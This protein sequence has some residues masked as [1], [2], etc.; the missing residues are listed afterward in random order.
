MLVSP[1]F[2]FRIEQ[3]PRAAPAA[4]PHQRSRTR[5]AALLLPV[6][7]HSRRRAARAGG[8][9]QAEGPGGAGAPGAPHARRSARRRAGR[10]L[11]RPVAPP[12]QRRDDR[13]RI[14]ILL[15]STKRC[16]RRSSPRPS[17]FV[18]SIV[19]EDRS[20]LEL[21]AADYTFLNQRLAEHYGIPQRLRLAV[22]PR[23]ADRSESPRPAGAGQHADGDVVS[24]P[25]L[26]GAARQVDS[27]EPARHAAAA[28]AADVPELKAAPHGKAADHARADGG[29]PRQ[30]D[31]RILPRADGPDRVRAGELRR[32]RQVADQGCGRA[33]RRQRASCRTA[34]DSRG[35]PG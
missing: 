30:P 28:A 11:R 24:Q 8:A 26:G 27:R 5:V 7:Q 32:R 20:L 16:A 10:Q 29:A 22:P 4:L 23:D 13:S 19:R 3:D 33:D 31:L 1:D 15:R 34:P 6:E 18:S 35:R 9:G 12:A 2:L 21:L 14:R 17:C 25:H